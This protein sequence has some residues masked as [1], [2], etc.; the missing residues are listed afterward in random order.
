MTGLNRVI[1]V[2]RE[3]GLVTVEAGIDWVQLINH[4]LWTFADQQDGVGHHP[5]ADRAPIT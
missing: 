5:E 4:L 2:D 3:R 1:D